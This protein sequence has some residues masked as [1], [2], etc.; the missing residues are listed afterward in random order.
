MWYNN[1][2]EY[3]QRDRD[4]NDEAKEGEIAVFEK[5]DYVYYASDGICR[6][7][8]LQYAPIKGMPPDRLYYVLRSL[9]TGNGVIYLPTDCDTVFIRRILSRE[10]AKA[11]LE[12]LPD[13]PLIEAPDAKALRERYIESMKKHDPREWVRVIKTV[14]ARAQK[15][16]Q[17]S[18]TQ[19]LSETERSYADDAKRYLCSELS[20]SL[21]IPGPEM[22]RYLAQQM[23]PA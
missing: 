15:L 2:V 5:G 23:M 16:A 4:P 12:E 18:R 9:H 7:E 8:D 3:R 11:L 21:E 6:V 19:R 20:L 13:L 17:V 22:E 14:T 1:I 10:E